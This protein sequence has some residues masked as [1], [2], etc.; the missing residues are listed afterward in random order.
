[1]PE[2]SHRFVTTNGIRMHVAEQGSGPL[3][4][5]LHGF[6]DSWYCWRHQLKALAEAGYRVVSPDQRGYGET[7][8]PEPI[9]AYDQ[10]ELA[11]DVAGLIEALDEQQ[12]VVVGHDWGASVAWHTAL[13]HPECVRA[14]VALSI[15][16]GGRPNVSHLTRM[17]ELFKDVFFY[18]LYFQKPGVA[19]AELEADVEKSMRHMLFSWSGAAPAN[20]V[21]KPKPKTATLLEGMLD[22]PDPLPAWLSEDDLRY[23]VARFQEHGFRGPL[24]WYRNFDRSWERT[25]HLATRKVTQP[26]LFIAGA[27]D[28]ALLMSAKPLARMPEWVPKLHRTV[29]IDGAGHWVQQEAPVETTRALL[30]FLRELD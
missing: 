25:S 17:R 21:M 7:E 22:L 10:V 12:A 20:V 3:I 14:V 23:Y 9:E 8:A 29:L 5:L 2:L 18:I 24:N 11:T 28:P 19:E 30:D 1:M 4:V 27:R 16:Y 6:P 13:L 15:P 26:A